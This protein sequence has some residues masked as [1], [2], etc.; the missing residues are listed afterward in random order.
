M[1]WIGC[2]FMGDNIRGMVVKLHVT[3][4][5][6]EFSLKRTMVALVKSIM[7]F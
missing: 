2:D 3:P 6:E 7:K 5:Q 1:N 4:K